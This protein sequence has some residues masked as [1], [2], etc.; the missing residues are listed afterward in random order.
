MFITLEGIEGSGKTTQIKHI[1][2]YLNQLGVPCIITREPGDTH[3]GKKIRSI[4]L[5]PENKGLDPLSEL[6]LYAAD[7]AQHL[8]ER[9]RPALEDGKT[10]VCD[11]FFDATTAYQGF[12]RGIDL[13]TIN[14]IHQLVLG[15]LKPDL[16]IL[17]DMSPEEGLQRAWKQVH[18][19][20]RTTAETRFENEEIS[21]HNKVRSGYL[22]LARSEPERFRIVDASKSAEQVREK[23]IILIDEAISKRS[24]K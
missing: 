1:T 5:D 15:D 22:E 10:V 6:F 21:F 18:E 4:L 2:D 23:I 24:D 8:K 16:T 12:A 13:D 19:G 17:F 14:R 20:S 3:I 7:R 11:R 9:I